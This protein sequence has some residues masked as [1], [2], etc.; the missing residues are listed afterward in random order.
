MLFRSRIRA[1]VER[2]RPFIRTETYH[3]PDRRRQNLPF[4]GPD[5]RDSIPVIVL[6][7]AIAGK[8]SF[9]VTAVPD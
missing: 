8:Y 2:P 1:V 6:F 4:N 3:G 9:A 5:R 7:Q